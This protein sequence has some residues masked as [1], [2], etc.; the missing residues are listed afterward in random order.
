MRDTTGHHLELLA[1]G[2]GD[3]DLLA[4]ALDPDA[5]EHGRLRVLGDALLT[6]AVTRW[7]FERAEDDDANALLSRREAFA[8]SRGRALR[9]CDLPEGA[10][11]ALLGAIVLDGGEGA[12]IAMVQRWLPPA[13][14]P[15]AEADAIVLFGEWHQRTYKRAPDPPTYTSEGSPPREYWH[16]TLV[17]EGLTVTGSGPRKQDAR[18]EACKQAMHR[19][20]E[21]RSASAPASNG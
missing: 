12:A 7:L 14:P 18:R 2:F 19:V 13:L 9:A 8:R 11:C 4:C 6:Y 10:A 15:L 1:Y 20:A 21:R 17:I 16:A 5:P 3:P